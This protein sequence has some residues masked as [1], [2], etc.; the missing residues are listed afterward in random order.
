MT[1]RA[2]LLSDQPIR[3]V[4]VALQG[5]GAHG[6]F[7]WGVLDRLLQEPDFEIVGISGTSAGAMNAGI[8]ADGLRRGGASEARKALERYWEDVGRMPGYASMMPPSFHANRSW[9]LDDN[10]LFLWHDMLTRIWSPYQ[11]NLLNYNP[12]RSLLKR[13][14]FEGLRS[15]A[16]AAGK[17]DDSIYRYDRAGLLMA[18][19]S[20][21]AGSGK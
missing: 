5:G 7:T 18:L 17:K 10:P 1:A 9:H 3:R 2:K 13:I 19:K 21:G 6:A 11:T 15:D 16:E 8:L 20:A 12:L 14:D 4:A